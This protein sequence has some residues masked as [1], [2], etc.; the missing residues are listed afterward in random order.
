MFLDDGKKL[1]SHPHRSADQRSLAWNP[2]NEPKYLMRVKIAG[3]IEKI[4]T[5]IR[6]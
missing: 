4:A 5:A 3:F 2:G 1:R 6:F